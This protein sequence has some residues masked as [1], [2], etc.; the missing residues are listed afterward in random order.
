MIYKIEGKKLTPK[1][2]VSFTLFVEA[3]SEKEASDKALKSEESI[4]N[5]STT[6]CEEVPKE[7]Y[8]EC[9]ECTYKNIKN[10]LVWVDNG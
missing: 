3:T 5:W 7:A 9:P 6:K 2:A 4:Q 10:P 8:L 1:G